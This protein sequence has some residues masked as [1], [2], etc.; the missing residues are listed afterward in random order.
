MGW[1]G[2]AGT[3][4][5][6]APTSETNPWQAPGKDHMPRFHSDDV[7]QD[8]PGRAFTTKKKHGWWGKEE[9]YDVHGRKME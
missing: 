6:G 8:N 2:D 3:R 4:G 9:R 1:G 7:D 5:W